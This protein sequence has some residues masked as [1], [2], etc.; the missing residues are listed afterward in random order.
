MRIQLITFF[1]FEFLMLN[2][3]VTYNLFLTGT[4]K[5]VNFKCYINEWQ[6]LT[7]KM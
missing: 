7:M 4:L 3:R 5:Y 2:L 6:Q 1:L